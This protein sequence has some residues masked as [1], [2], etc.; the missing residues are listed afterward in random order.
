MDKSYWISSW[1]E[2]KKEYPK[3]EKDMPY[4]F[5]S[6]HYFNEDIIAALATVDRSAYALIGTTDQVENNTLMYAAWAYGL[7]Y[8]DRRSQESRKQSILKMEHVL[9]N[10]T[11]VIMYP[12]GGWNNTENLICKRLF[13]S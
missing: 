6:T 1:I 7:I 3:L 9:N 2:N 10:G 12:E 13:A 4:I 8:V 11:S 5:A